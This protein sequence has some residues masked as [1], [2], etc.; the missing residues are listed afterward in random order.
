MTAPL[1]PLLADLRGAY[2]AQ[3]LGCIK[4][5]LDE[6]ERV[7]YQWEVAVLEAVYDSVP[8]ML[9]FHDPGFVIELQRQT[10]LAIQS[11]RRLRLGYRRDRRG[12]IVGPR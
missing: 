10:A 7:I 11:L 6:L 5:D 8:E 4:V 12:F 1:K 9:P 2:R 3:L